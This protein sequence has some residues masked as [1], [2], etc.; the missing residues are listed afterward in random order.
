MSI[1]VCVCVFMGSPSLELS[2]R[3][4]RYM[5]MF[6]MLLL[7]L[8]LFVGGVVVVSVVAAVDDEDD[9]DGAVVLIKLDTALSS[10]A[11]NCCRVDL[12]LICI[13]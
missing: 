9:A 1:C 11:K 5:T 10:A 8:L 3:L 4:L 6:P 13:L 12:C 7:L 2:S